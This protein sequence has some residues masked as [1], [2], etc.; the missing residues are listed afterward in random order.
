MSR[1]PEDKVAPDGR[2]SKSI[3]EREGEVIVTFAGRVVER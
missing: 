1:K 3:R 2:G